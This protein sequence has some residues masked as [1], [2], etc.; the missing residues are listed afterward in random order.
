MASVST[1]LKQLAF[2]HVLVKIELN[3][4]EE[5]VLLLVMKHSTEM[6]FAMVEDEAFALS[7]FV[8]LPDLEEFVCKA[9]DL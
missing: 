8:L 2:C 3:I 1:I 7:K 9:T 5:R 6:P 4:P